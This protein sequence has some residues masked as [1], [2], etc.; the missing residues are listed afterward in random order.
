MRLTPELREA[1]GVA[2]ARAEMELASWVRA[3]LQHA[4]RC[5]ELERATDAAREG[6]VR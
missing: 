2:A 6:I 1:I 5:P 4:L 3:A